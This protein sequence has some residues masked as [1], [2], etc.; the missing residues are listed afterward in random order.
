MDHATTNWWRQ[1]MNWNFSVLCYSESRPAI[2]TKQKFKHT[3]ATVLVLELQSISC[4]SRPSCIRVR[5]SRTARMG[6]CGGEG[7]WTAAHLMSW[8]GRFGEGSKILE[9]LDGI[10]KQRKQIMV[11]K[12]RALKSWEVARGGGQE[13]IEKYVRGWEA[14]LT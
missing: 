5:E 7:D 10:Y 2:N 14:G 11:L 9:E 8:Q 13:V 1:S 4:H 6:W 3:P 12:E